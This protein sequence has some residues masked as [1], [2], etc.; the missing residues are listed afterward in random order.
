M[1]ARTDTGCVVLP[2]VFGANVR[3]IRR[4]AGARTLETG[5]ETMPPAIRMAPVTVVLAA[6]ASGAPAVV[7]VGSVGA[8]APGC[9]G[10]AGGGAGCESIVVAVVVDAGTV[11]VVGRPGSVTV[12]S[13]GRVIV[14]RPS[15]SAWSVDVDSAKPSA[16][17]TAS[18]APWV[19]TRGQRAGRCSFKGPPSRRGRG[20]VAYLSNSR[21]PAAPVDPS[22]T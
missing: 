21:R 13:P 8:G 15:A 3:R 4:R 2:I 22:H 11:A 18:H 10:G 7:A 20:R 1:R 9:V 19:A 14:G 12:V 17:V 5:I 16:A 6:G